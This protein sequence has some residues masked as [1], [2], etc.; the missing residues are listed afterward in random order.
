MLIAP[1]PIR[2]NGSS[3]TEMKFW[4]FPLERESLA[5]NAT[6]TAL[7]MVHVT[8]ARLRRGRDNITPSFSIDREN[9]VATLQVGTQC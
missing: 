1:P 3:K 6:K 7:T 9:K 2:T 8:A 5:H 4:I